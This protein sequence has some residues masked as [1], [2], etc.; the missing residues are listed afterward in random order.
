MAAYIDIP[1]IQ[2][3]LKTLPGG[4]P[5]LGRADS[6]EN[7]HFARELEHIIPEMFEF[8]HA[9]INARKVFPID[10]S[11]GPTADK[12]TFRQFTKVGQAKIISDY[13]NNIPLVNVFGEEFTGNVRS[14]AIAAM[15]SLNEIRKSTS[16][17][18]PLDREQSDAAREAMLRLENKLA[19]N[20]DPDNGLVGL[21]TDP[22]IPTTTVVDPGGGTEWVNKT[23]QQIYD[24][25]CTCGN[26]IVE[27]TG[28]VEAPSRLLLPTAQYNLAFCQNFGAGTDTTTLRY[29]LNNNPYIKEVMPVRELKG[30]GT[31][32]SDVM[33]AYEPNMS[34]LRLNIPLEVEQLPPQEVDLNV[35]VIYHQRFGGLTVHKP[36]SLH[37]CE[38]I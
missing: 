28:D 16:V 11:A 5:S 24:D 27:T 14:I 7:I 38:G 6:A 10:R 4:I 8:E 19:F 36:Y 21:F 12:I 9:R 31:G 20:G 37:I 34:K 18:R 15:W 33:I 3:L 30:A 22:N 32:G 23:A 26:T 2:D 13:E 29:Y 17:G 25:M 35:K 1:N